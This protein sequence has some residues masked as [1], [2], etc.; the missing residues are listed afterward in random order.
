MNQQRRHGAFFVHYYHYVVTA[1]DARNRTAAAIAANPAAMPADALIAIVF[2]ALGVE[3]FINELAEMA[4]R[5]ADMYGP[6][7]GGTATLRDL[8]TTLVEIEDARGPVELKY[9][10]AS[11]ILSGRTFDQGAQPFQDFRDLMRLRDALVSWF[12]SATGIGRMKP[13]EFRQ[14]LPW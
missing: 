13:A 1:Y 14:A 3:A 6:G 12:T 9:Q 2:A 8:A 5:D 7:L 11:K 4:Q 10:M